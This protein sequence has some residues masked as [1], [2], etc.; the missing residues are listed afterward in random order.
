MAILRAVG[1]GVTACPR[2]GEAMG[3]LA[4]IDLVLEENRITALIGESGAGKTILCKALS[5]LL[6]ASVRVTAGRLLWQGE[7]VTAEKWPGLRGKTI[8]Y[9]P[10]NA[11]ASFNPVMKIGEQ[12]AE[13]ARVPEGRVKEMM[14]FL[15]L[16]DPDRVLAAYP[17][18]LSEGENQRALLCLALSMN[19]QI[20]LL[21]EPTSSLDMEVQEEFIVLIK[22]LQSEFRLTILLVSHNLGLVAGIA[23]YIYLI[24]FG[25]LVEHGTF[26][27][28]LENP[29]HP[30][31][32]EILSL[33]RPL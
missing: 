30:Y 6:P 31:T 1:L 2:R 25:R 24:Q 19:P 12:I 20:L 22:K 3:L 23:D 18:E 33:I 14:A 4:D 15:N 17:F 7:E 11:A 28:L 32:R 10:Q 21:D 13:T 8:F 16:A 27:R 5:G 26:A 29:A 9:A